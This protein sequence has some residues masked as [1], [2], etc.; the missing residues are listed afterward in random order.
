MFGLF[1]VKII[2]HY[3]TFFKKYDSTKLVSM[4]T[5]GAGVLELFE[6]LHKHFLISLP[7][8][9][10]KRSEKYSKIKEHLGNLM[11]KRKLLFC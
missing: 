9:W 5:V 4:K 11:L 10:F 7:K 1:F 2:S 8:K 3:S 6:K